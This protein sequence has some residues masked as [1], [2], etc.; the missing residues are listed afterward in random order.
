MQYCSIYTRTHDHAHIITCM[1]PVRA[2]AWSS[3][4]R[5]LPPFL[6][7]ISAASRGGG[8]PYEPASSVR[9]PNVNRNASSA[10]SKQANTCSGSHCNTTEPPAANHPIFCLS[11]VLVVLFGQA[12]LADG[13]AGGGFPRPKNNPM[14][15]GN[16]FA[17]LTIL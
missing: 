4:R 3:S 8:S 12:L 5:L 1:V 10:N 11:L 15:V 7:W 6:R 14:L 2:S 16:P 13:G 17:C 9:L